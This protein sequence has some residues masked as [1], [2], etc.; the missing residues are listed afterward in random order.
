M[1]T[2]YFNIIAAKCKPITAIFMSKKIAMPGGKTVILTA[3]A[4]LDA[5]WY[6]NIIDRW[7]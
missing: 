4:G 5:Q 1:D 3:L 6:N 7:G 2:L